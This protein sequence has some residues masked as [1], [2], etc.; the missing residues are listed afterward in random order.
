MIKQHRIVTAMLVSLSLVGMAVAPAMAQSIDFL[1]RTT[2]E[3]A[4][5]LYT[6]GSFAA[7]SIFLVT[8]DGVI[9]TDPVSVEHAAKMRAAIARVTDQPVKYV[10]YSHEHWDHVLGGQIFKDDG[11]TIISHRKCV[12]YFEDNPHPDLVMPDETVSDTTE[13]TLG[14]KTL[15]LMY[16]GE[17]H[18]KCTLVMQLDGTDVLF[19]NDLV[20]PFSVGL[21]TMPDYDP[22]DWVRTLREMEAM[23][24]WSRMVGGHGPPS[25]PKAA[26]VERRRYLEALMASVKEQMDA[27]KGMR[28]IIADTSLPEFSHMS[29]YEAQ[30][31]RAAERIYYYYSMGW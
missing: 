29:G 27:G 12:P 10:V 20:T 5:D 14:G 2:T 21:G 11:A 8:D 3:L 24:G 9:A 19:V 31:D 25:A 16:F 1:R 6:F 7:R 30:I 28:E 18:G 23:T 17:N 13:L 15:R 26:L 4:P 22:G